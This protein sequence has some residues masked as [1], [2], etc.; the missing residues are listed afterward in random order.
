MSA[1]RHVTDD[2]RRLVLDMAARV[3]RECAVEKTGSGSLGPLRDAHSYR[4]DSRGFSLYRPT[5]MERDRARAWH[6]YWQPLGYQTTDET[7]MAAAPG[8]PFGPEH[9]TWGTWLTFTWAMIRAELAAA[10]GD[11]QLDLF[12]EAA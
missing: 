11:V 12:G 6:D 2:E 4:T 3:L 9:G 7:L 1:F 8:R 5:P 10:A